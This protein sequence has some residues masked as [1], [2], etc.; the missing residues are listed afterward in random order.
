MSAANGREKCFSPPSPK[1][2]APSFLT[3]IKNKKLPDNITSL[4]PKAALYLNT[5][6]DVQFAYLF[7]GLS[8]GLP[9]PLSDVD[10]AVFLQPQAD[11]IERKMEILGELTDILKT[12]EIDLVI[13]NKAP[14]PL[15]MRILSNKKVLVDKKPFDRNAYESLIIRKYMDFSFIEKGILKRRFPN[16]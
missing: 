1:L 9:K 5:L 8:R 2:L 12:D 13:L 16:G 7:G 10:I 6:P 4:I 3:M 14:L 15:K 11:M